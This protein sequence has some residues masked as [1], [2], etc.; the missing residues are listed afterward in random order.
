MWLLSC[1]HILTLAVAATAAEADPS[2]N[3]ALPQSISS[4]QTYFAIPFQVDQPASAAAGAAAVQLH[5]STD[6]GE[7][8]S[9]YASV[10]PSQARFL[11]RAPRDG[12]YWFGVRTLDRSNQLRPAEIDRPG[13][14]VIVDTS[15]PKLTLQAQHGESGLVTARWQVVEQLLDHNSLAILYR[16]GPDLPWL[17]VATEREDAASAQSARSGSVSWMPVSGPGPLEVRAEI[18]DTAGNRDISYTQVLFDRNLDTLAASASAMPFAAE[19][20]TNPIRTRG[21]QPTASLALRDSGP[22]PRTDEPGGGR[23]G[24]QTAPDTFAADT[25]YNHGRLTTAD[26]PLVS[27][28]GGESTGENRFDGWRAAAKELPSD[29]HGGDLAR[30]GEAEY[31]MPG[32]VEYGTSSPDRAIAAKSNPP[33][34]NEF[35]RSLETRV[36]LGRHDDSL[37]QP[38]SRTVNSRSFELGYDVD[39]APSET[40]DRVELWGTRDEGRTW[41]SYCVDKD[42]RSPILAT[43]P[44]EGTYG[45]RITV[46]SSRDPV[47]QSPRPGDQ[48]DMLV[49]VDLTDPAARILWAE[50]AAD[51]PEGRITVRW[52]ATDA[53]LAQRPISLYYAV[54]PGGPWNPVAQDLE[55]NGQYEWLAQRNLPDRIH[56]R[57]EVR[58]E[59]GNIGVS[60]TTQPI[61]LTGKRPAVNFI[62]REDESARVPPRRYYPR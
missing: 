40:P 34:R 11:F 9:Q 37:P 10:R 19:T 56:L 25:Q 41:Q 55:N 61:E 54:Y 1:T 38:R 15:P 59:A 2:G 12:E 14:I 49:T 58:D 35:T 45:F 42:G 60:E 13:L 31:S 39:A 36:P 57:L 21:T 29:T 51:N 48:P 50:R 62:R 17:T 3:R 27:M 33:I 47:G 32:P 52:D 4:R 8:W 5:V 30:H 28:I 26:Q 53:C 23:Y 44:A 24:L 18:A 22:L 7:T 6:R 43:V 46:S 20:D 16:S